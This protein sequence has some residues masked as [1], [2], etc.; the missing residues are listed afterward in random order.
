MRA[1]GADQEA[2]RLDER[3]ELGTPLGNCGG[4]VR[5]RLLP[6][7]AHFHLGRD[8]L[9]DQVLLERRALRSGLHVLEAV[10]ELERLR[11]EERELLLDRDAEVGRAFEVLARPIDLLGR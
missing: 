9:A 1:G 6:P 7:R 11:V 10:R 3:A 8:Q 4:Y 5:E 2:H